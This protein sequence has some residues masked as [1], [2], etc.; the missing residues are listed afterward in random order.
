[1][2]KIRFALIGWGWRAQFYYRIAKL[3]PA[4]FEL[5]TVLCR[6]KEKGEAI[7]REFGVN[8]VYSLEDVLADAPDF[9]VLCIK[10][11]HVSEYLKTLIERQIP[12]LAETP[13]AETVEELSS[14]WETCAFTGAK[15][16]VAEQYIY[17]PLYA[18]WY[19]VIQA[20]LLGEIQN[21]N[22]SSL[23]G[24]HGVSI[25]RMFLGVGYEHCTVRGKQYT[26]RLTET[27]ARDG[28]VFDGKII[29]ST[30]NRLT[31]EFDGGKVAFF[32]FSDP[33]QYHSFIRTRQLN[34]QGTR[35][36]IDDLTIRYLADGNIPVS[37]SL[38]RIDM[39]VY[40]N[41]EWA[42]KAIFLGERKLYENPFPCARLNDDELAVAT[43]LTGMKR[44]LDTGEEVY[45][46]RDALQDTYLSLL[47]DEA[48]AAA[49]TP[50]RS[51]AMPW[52]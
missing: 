13:P 21:I 47:M 19:Q 32:D 44:Y 18:A 34:V 45:S 51:R 23:H 37:Q 4:C 35:G 20:G 11:G 42:H 39:G 52:M 46:L 3:V 40:N 7:A 50:V 43:C 27:L 49:G 24:Y 17:Q 36:E 38:N 1:M 5:T 41:Q 2:T 15:V 29:P 48:M 6:S 22:L 10:R 9:V 25:I 30:R 26:F 8:P 33:A 16:Q 12:V 28:E 31:L 14:L